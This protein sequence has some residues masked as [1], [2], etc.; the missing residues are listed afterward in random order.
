MVLGINKEYNNDEIREFVNHYM[1]LMHGSTGKYL[2]TD[3]FAGF[4]S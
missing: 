4:K 3:V 1:K 2:Y